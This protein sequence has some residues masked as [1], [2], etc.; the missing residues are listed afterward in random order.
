MNTVQLCSETSKYISLD[1]FETMKGMHEW[2]W[3]KCDAFQHKRFSKQR[4]ISS[5]RDLLN[6]LASFG[7]FPYTEKAT[8]MTPE[9]ASCIDNVYV[10]AIS[11]YCRSGIVQTSLSDHY[12]VVLCI[13]LPKSRNCSKSRK[14]KM[15]SHYRIQSDESF[16]RIED[17]L[18]RYVWSVISQGEVNGAYDS[19]LRVLCMIIDRVMPVRTKT[20]RAEN[21][22]NVPWLTKGFAKVALNLINCIHSIPKKMHFKPSSICMTNSTWF[23]RADGVYVRGTHQVACQFE[24]NLVAM[25]TLMK[26]RLW[27]KFRNFTETDIRH[28]IKKRLYLIVNSTFK[29]GPLAIAV[30]L[31]S[32]SL[33]AGK[34]CANEMDTDSGGVQVIVNYLTSDQA[35]CETSSSI[36]ERIAALER[37]VD[38]LK[39]AGAE[40]GAGEGCGCP[41]GPPGP[42]GRVGPSGPRGPR[43][44][45]GAR[46]TFGGT[47]ATGL[48]GSTGVGGRDG[49]PGAPGA[50]GRTG[51]TGATGY[52]GQTGA[53]GWLGRTGAGPS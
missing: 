9:A 25:T 50:P 34:K 3:S 21:V 32:L 30:V 11:N 27:A 19:F 52:Q 2:Q 16:R 40:S 41:S 10:R 8:R 6:E 53:T 46:G 14:E 20:M 31:S 4:E 7:Y 22:I 5:P 39:H 42:P 12:P 38:F 48:R 47:G 44:L 24:M 43:G 18:L 1:E 15:T 35:T 28:Q 51:S 36:L 37:E 17:D 29:M 49:A 33:V 26:E 13:D 45:K 23:R